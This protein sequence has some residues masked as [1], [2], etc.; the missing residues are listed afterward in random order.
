MQFGH[1]AMVLYVAAC[2]VKE[3]DVNQATNWGDECRTPGESGYSALPGGRGPHPPSF[4][5]AQQRH[6]DVVCYLVPEVGADANQA[7]NDGRTHLFIAVAKQNMD[8][9]RSLLKDLG[10]DIKQAAYNGRTP[11]VGVAPL[12]NDDKHVRYYTCSRMVRSRALKPQQLTL[13]RPR[14]SNSKKIDASA[15]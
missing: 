6:L 8:V 15:N 3:F 10:T 2:L 4:I 12:N 1:L 11:A 9:V 5:T 7:D 13:A 14:T